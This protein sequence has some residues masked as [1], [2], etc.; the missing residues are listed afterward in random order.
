MTSPFDLVDG[1]F[2]VLVNTRGQHSLWPAGIDRPTGWEQVHGPADRQTCLSY[3]TERWADQRTA[4]PERIPLSN[5]Q[6]FLVAFDRG[7]TD[8]A[9]GARHT[10][11][12]A[13]RV[14]G[15]VDQDVLSAALDDVVARH[16]ILR[17]VLVPGADG[18]HQEVYPAGPVSLTVRTLSDVDAVDRGR[19]AEELLNEIDAEPFPIQDLP[20][21]RAV[22]GRFDGT[23]SVLV[24]ASH[25]TA[26]DGWSMGIILSDLAACYTA[27]LSGHPADLPAA[28]PYREFA[29]WQQTAEAEPSAKAV[30]YW[31]NKLAGAS[32][33]AIPTDRPLPE[34]TPDRY[35]AHRFVIDAELSAEV[36]AFA[37][38]TRSSPFMVLLAAYHVLLRALTGVTD[39]VTPTFTIGRYD[40]RFTAT[41]GPFFNML[42]LRTDLT[43]CR[44][45]LD[46]LEVTRAACGESY[47][48]DIPF[49]AIVAEVPAITTAFGDRNGAVAAFEMLR[50]PSTS[51]RVALGEAACTAIRDRGL[52]QPVSSSIP[53]GALWALDVLPTGEIAGS[54]KYNRNTIDDTTIADIVS[55]FQRALRDALAS[56]QAPLPAD[57]KGFRA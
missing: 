13:W 37:R 39:I 16:E 42:P 40:D 34:D 54:L 45:F 11:V 55:G 28:A 26:T 17:T 33:L 19:V 50:D 25:H 52:F 3:V 22:L 24:L 49:S 47:T 46:V 41:V 30:A 44:H 6:K 53:N 35:A 29:S 20:H 8:G 43:G 18:G 15:A 31:R 57:P 51:E 14:A 36:S 5:N 1:S 48:R 21:L 23:D 32:M 9:L 12:S 27:R 38:S 10:L 2:S 56:P 7:D 4:E